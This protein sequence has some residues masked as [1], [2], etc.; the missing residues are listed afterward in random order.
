PPEQLCN[1]HRI[2]DPWM[3]NND[4]C[5]THPS[6]AIELALGFNMQ[7]LGQLIVDDPHFLRNATF[8]MPP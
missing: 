5:F 3:G 6:Q 7:T 4:W 1:S 2:V 8:Q